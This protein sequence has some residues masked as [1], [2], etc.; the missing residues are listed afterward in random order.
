LPA[1][2][3]RFSYSGYNEFAI[4]TTKYIILRK[5]EAQYNI[6]NVDSFAVAEK[7]GP[8]SRGCAS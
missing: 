3:L 5:T 2:I 4:G 1:R 8:V 6:C 7:L